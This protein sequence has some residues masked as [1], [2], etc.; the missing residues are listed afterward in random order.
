MALLIAQWVGTKCSEASRPKVYELIL[1]L[2]SPLDP[3]NDVVVRM[4]AA[5]ALSD[6]VNEWD[7][8]VD[9]F[10]PFL[11]AFLVG[12][13]EEENKGG[14]IGLMAFVQHIE[15]RM[16]LIRVVEVIVERT[17]RGVLSL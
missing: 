16:K 10:L 14:I 17:D 9:D 11:D 6:A 15:A 1:S 8:K 3:R 12:T 4:C 2:L 5:N 13:A 7:F